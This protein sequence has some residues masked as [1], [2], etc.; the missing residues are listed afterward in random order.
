MKTWRLSIKKTYA[1]RTA[2]KL[3]G[4]MPKSN[5]CARIIKALNGTNNI[6]KT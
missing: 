6:G 5:Q 4:L 3:L 1:E 2:I